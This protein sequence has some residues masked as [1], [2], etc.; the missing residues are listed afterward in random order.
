MKAVKRVIFLFLVLNIV[1][2]GLMAADKVVV[3]PLLSH[4]SKP[5]KNVVTVAK[6]GGDFT[7][8]VAAMASITDASETN[9]YLVIIG[10]GIYAISRS[11]QVPGYVT[12]IGSGFE[13]TTL[14]GYVS[15]DQDYIACALVNLEGPSSSL[16]DLFVQNR[17][18]GK[19]SVGVFVGGYCS[20][21][22]ASVYVSGSEQNVG[23]Y[24]GEGVLE[25]VSVTAI[26]GEQA[27]GVMSSGTQ[28]PLQH[29]SVSALNAQQISVGIEF[30]QRARIVS[31]VAIKATGSTYAIG[32][33]YKDCMT[34][35]LLNGVR[36]TAADAPESYGIFSYNTNYQAPVTLRRSTIFGQSKSILVKN[37]S[38]VNNILLINASQSTLL[39]EISIIGNGG[40]IKKC[41]ACDNGTGN[42][43]NNNCQ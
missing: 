41:V 40:E 3:I 34:N 43:L 13:A 6:S 10:P 8:P 16:T 22:Q 15:H 26:G 19:R 2:A 39:G 14:T 20:F 11:L 7:D 27:T 9:P 25:D 1:P 30:D 36:I 33:R 23:V 38:N 18:G 17:G 31:D 29:L 24:T 21:R 42:T 32:I 28:L 5:I 4:Q 37:Y 35:G 12:I